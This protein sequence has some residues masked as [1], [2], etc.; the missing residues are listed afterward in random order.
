VAVTTK[1]EKSIEADRFCS[2]QLWL[3]SPKIQSQGAGSDRFNWDFDETLASHL[4][5]VCEPRH[6]VGFFGLRMILQNLRRGCHR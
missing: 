2:S 1:H 5:A 4:G 3:V 6:D